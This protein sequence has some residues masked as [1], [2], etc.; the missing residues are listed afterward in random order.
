MADCQQAVE[1]VRDHLVAQ[2]KSL[3][4]PNVNAQIIQQKAFL[5][6]KELYRFLAR[7]HAKLSEEIGQAYIYTMR[8][9]HLNHFT[10]YSQALERLKLHVL[11]RHDM[12]GQS[13]SSR[14]G[15]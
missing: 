14:K 1:R 2:V 3:R 10:R 8:W 4:S 13:D 7:R 9:Y 15:E 5:S 6:V 12:L 11:E